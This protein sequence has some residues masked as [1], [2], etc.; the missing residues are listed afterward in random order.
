LCARI[1]CG[2]VG[3]VARRKHNRAPLLSGQG[4]KQSSLAGELHIVFTGCVNVHVRIRGRGVDY[5]PRDQS[6]GAQKKQQ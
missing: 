2:H 1:R 3:L 5:R 4:R 6:A